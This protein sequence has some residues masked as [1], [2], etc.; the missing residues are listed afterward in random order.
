MS[1]APDA[2]NRL[3]AHLCES[4][5]GSNMNLLLSF[6]AWAFHRHHNI[7]LVGH[8]RVPVRILPCARCG[9]GSLWLPNRIWWEKWQEAKW[10]P[11]H[12]AII[13]SARP[14]SAT[15]PEQASGVPRK[16][17][18][19][20]RRRR[21]GNGVSKSRWFGATWLSGLSRKGLTESPLN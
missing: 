4:G 17:N 18:R 1:V 2:W 8:H 11:P 3:V 20:S 6:T 19:Y 13:R 10:S 21:I 15:A 5:T 12:F 16:R 14:E 9:S 7:V